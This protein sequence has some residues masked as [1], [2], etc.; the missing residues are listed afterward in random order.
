VH[1]GVARID[2]LGGNVLMWVDF[3]FAGFSATCKEKGFWL[4]RERERES[5]V[6]ELWI[7]CFCWEGGGEGRDLGGV[8][9]VRD[10]VEKLLPS[11]WVHAI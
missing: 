3:V 9:K 1:G 6:L 8:W 7:W 4:W 10:F 11:F 5:C 2:L